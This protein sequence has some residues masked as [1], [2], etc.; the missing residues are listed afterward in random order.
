MILD[1]V[2]NITPTYSVSIKDKFKTDMQESCPI[3]SYS[4]VK[5]IEKISGKPITLA[6][7]SNK[8]KLD[9]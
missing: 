4:I 7:C 2:K 1:L 9:S 5:V 6:N 8:L 3:V